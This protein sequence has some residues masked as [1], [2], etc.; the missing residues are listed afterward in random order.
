MDLTGSESYS[1]YIKNVSAPTTAGKQQLWGPI[2]DATGQPVAW[3]ADNST[4]FTVG[5]ERGGRRSTLLWR[6]TVG[7]RGLSRGL[8]VHNETEAGKW[9]SLGRS[10]NHGVLYLLSSSASTTTASILP[11]SNPTGVTPPRCLCHLWPRLLSDRHHS[12]S[13]RSLGVVG[14]QGEHTHVLCNEGTQNLTPHP[15]RPHLG[16]HCSVI[17]QHSSSG[18]VP[19]T[20]RSRLPQQVGCR[21]LEAG[22]TRAL[23]ECGPPWLPRWRGGRCTGSRRGALR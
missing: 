16:C 4:L 10:H 22:S 14:L 23:Q 5:T 19:S 21:V 3:A 17:Y 2:A 7:P 8:L 12:I 11:A 15:G 13:C 18:I 20:A 1:L 6:Y 9:L